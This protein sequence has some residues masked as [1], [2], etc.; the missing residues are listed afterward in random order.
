[1]GLRLASVA[2]ALGALVL[3]DRADAACQLKPMAELPINTAGLRLLTRAKIDGVEVPFIVD[4]G[5]FF[6]MLTPGAAAR[7]HL[8]VGPVPFG[9]S[10]IGAGG[11]SMKIGQTRVGVFTLSGHDYQNVLFLVGEKDWGGGAVGL[12][13]QNVLGEAEVEYDLPHGVMR[14]FKAIGCSRDDNL[15]YWTGSQPYSEIDIEP[16][17]RTQP[18]AKAQA[19]LNGVPIRVEFDTGAPNSAL[20]LSGALKAGVKPGDPGVVKSGY[21]SG[22]TAGSYHRK[23][24][25]PFSSFK[26]GDEQIKNFKLTIGDFGLRGEFDMLVGAD[27]FISHRV[28]ISN[29]QRKAYFTYVGGPVFNMASPPKAGAETVAAPTGGSAADRRRRLLQGRLR[30]PRAP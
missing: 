14:L 13:G 15:A 28:L 16:T 2:L 19:M 22:I 8:P 23:W 24:L 27:F 11:Q 29:T 6:S 12:I 25:A 7:F 21:K 18:H 17:D 30:R 20:N 4:S 5:A 10:V 1:M 9:F 3:A 26:M